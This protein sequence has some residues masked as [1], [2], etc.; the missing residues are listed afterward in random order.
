MV[1]CPPNSQ[2][3]WYQSVAGS[4][5]PR[6][7]GRGRRLATG[8]CGGC[9]LVASQLPRW[10]SWTKG[11]VY[12]PQV[13]V[14]VQG[15]MCVSLQRS[16]PS[17]LQTR[18]RILDSRQQGGMIPNL[19]RSLLSCLIQVK[20][21][22]SAQHA[23]E[24]GAWNKRMCTGCASCSQAEGF[25]A[26]VFDCASTLTVQGARVSC[27]K[28]L[29]HGVKCNIGCNISEEILAGMTHG[30]RGAPVRL[31]PN[32]PFNADPNVGLQK[33]SRGMAMR[34]ERLRKHLVI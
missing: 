8:K 14:L 13:P 18:R 2:R 11:V 34:M 3:S 33:R 6:G 28:C 9:V 23:Q 20:R 17:G 16:V 4:S 10:T 25:F 7:R 29:Y 15:M 32:A 26:R 12:R 30:W 27:A 22:R 5:A 19:K 31:A 21:W 1:A 24:H